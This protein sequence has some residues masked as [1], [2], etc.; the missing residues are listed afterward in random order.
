MMVLR[1]KKINWLGSKLREAFEGQCARSSLIGRYVWKNGHV[2]WA[3]EHLKDADSDDR[4]KRATSVIIR[5][6]PLANTHDSLV[7]CEQSFQRVL[8]IEG[9]FQEFKKT[10]KHFKK[11]CKF[12]AY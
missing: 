3:G 2:R 9:Q 5:Q 11:C 12:Y 8:A 7:H 6:H 1:G 4:G 10:K